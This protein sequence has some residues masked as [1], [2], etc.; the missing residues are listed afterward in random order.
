MSLL[1]DPRITPKQAAGI[2]WLLDIRNSATVFTMMNENGTVFDENRMTQAGTT[3]VPD[4]Q[5]PTK[6]EDAMGTIWRSKVANFYAEHDSRSRAE[7]LL[8]AQGY[9]PAP[10]NEKAAAQYLIAHW[11]ELADLGVLDQ[12]GNLSSSLISNYI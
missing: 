8:I 1:Q 12:N 6:M 2:G 11:G 4:A 10:A 5:L 3:L 7:I 9:H